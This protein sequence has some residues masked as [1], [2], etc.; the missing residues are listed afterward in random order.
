[1]VDLDFTRLCKHLQAN[2]AET[3][4][5]YWRSLPARHEVQRFTREE[6]RTLEDLVLA[7]KDQD[8]RAY[9]ILSLSAVYALGGVAAGEKPTEKSSEKL[10]DWLFEP[11]SHVRKDARAGTQSSLVLSVCDNQYIRDVQAQV[12]IARLLRRTGIRRRNSGTCRTS[13]PTGR[14]RAGSGAGICFIGRP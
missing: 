5:K 13:T 1:M 14:C 8:L 9:A 11:F 7:E 2:D 10:S 4:K 6:I 12:E 3:K